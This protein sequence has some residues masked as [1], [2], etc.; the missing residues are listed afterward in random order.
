MYRG[1]RLGILALA[2]A[3]ALT[4]GCASTGAEQPS[5]F[6]QA[7]EAY[8]AQNYGIALPLMQAE[9]Q[10][11]N[12]RAQYTLGYMYFYGLGMERDAEQAMYWIRQAAERGDA[13]AVQ[14]LEKLAGVGQ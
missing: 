12:P 14:A 7:R 2:L 5:R 10:A 13:R 8:Q 6:E 4:A 3:T 1:N 9:A 11:G